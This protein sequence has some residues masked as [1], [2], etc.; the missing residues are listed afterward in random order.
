MRIGLFGGSFDPVHKGHIALAKYVRKQC[1]LDEVWFLPTVKTPLKDFKQTAFED[2]VE[3]LEWALKPFKYLKVCTI[4]ASLPVPSYTINT[5]RKLK[6]MYPNDEFYFMIGND[7]YEQIEQ[8]REYESLI[9]LIQFIVVNRSE[10]VENEDSRFIFLK[11][12]DRRESSTLVREGHFDMVPRSVLRVIH[13]KGLYYDSVAKANMR[14]KRYKHSLS[15]AEVCKDLAMAHHL[16]V[17]KAVQIGLL[18][19]VAKQWDKELCKELMQR[20][21]P[22]YAD[23]AEPVYHQYLAMYYLKHHLFIQDKVMLRA[24]GHHVKGD[25]DDPYALIV[26]IADKTEPTRGYDS[27]RELNLARKDLKAAAELIKEEQRAYI[28]KTEGKH[29]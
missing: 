9:T 28:L 7:Q 25:C 27:T 6:E 11:E 20:F 19:D 13:E 5:V 8:W 23:E 15:V 17:D 22:E 14:E 18:H 12:F 4:E 21:Y 16:D 1:H 24:I 2:R 26:Y 3:M 10:V 29:V